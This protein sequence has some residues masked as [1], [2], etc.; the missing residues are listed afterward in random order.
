MPWLNSA[1]YRAEIVAT[2]DYTE[3]RLEIYDKIIQCWDDGGSAVLFN[4]LMKELS[5]LDTEFQNYR[6]EQ[7]NKRNP[8][9]TSGLLEMLRA[10]PKEAQ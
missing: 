10:G 1:E 7:D 6:E 8:R 9:R 2:R 4:N 5:D 3:K